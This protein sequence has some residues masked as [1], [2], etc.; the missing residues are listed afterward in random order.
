MCRQA[1]WPDEWF[2][3]KSTSAQ[4]RGS[5]REG[6]DR[7]FVNCSQTPP[8]NCQSDSASQVT[9]RTDC[10]GRLKNKSLWASR[11][12]GKKKQAGP[13]PSALT[14]A[15][16]A[17]AAIPGGNRMGAGSFT[18]QVFTGHL[19]ILDT[20]ARVAVKGRPETL[21]Q[22]SLGTAHLPGTGTE[23]TQARSSGFLTHMWLPGTSRKR[24]LFQASHL[25]GLWAR[26]GSLLPPPGGVRGVGGSPGGRNLA[27]GW[28]ATVWERMWVG[29]GW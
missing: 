14:S 27:L 20:R 6:P 1:G 28:I 22:G 10:G 23:S 4:T 21:H 16:R 18:P 13:S 15:R 25:Q 12:N 7:Q 26:K 9:P 5:Q 2:P 17:T 24:A 3:L 11:G 8:L 19:S 29:P